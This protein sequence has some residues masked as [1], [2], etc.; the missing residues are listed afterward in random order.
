MDFQKS[1]SNVDRI[2]IFSGGSLR[3]SFAP[4]KVGKNDIELKDA[5]TQ[6]PQTVV[7]NNAKS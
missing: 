1:K 7:I 4:L 6:L 5:S 2:A 3:S